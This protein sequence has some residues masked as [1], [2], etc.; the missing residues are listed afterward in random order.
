MWNFT[1]S[2]AQ[3]YVKSIAQHSKSAVQKTREFSTD[4]WVC[5]KPST[6]SCRKIVG[7]SIE[8]WC[9]ELT[10]LSSISRTRRRGN[11]KLREFVDCSSFHYPQ[12]S[13]SNISATKRIHFSFPWHKHLFQ[14]CWQLIHHKRA[15]YS[16]AWIRRPYRGIVRL[17]CY[18]KGLF[19]ATLIFIQTTGFSLQQASGAF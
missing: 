15:W 18:F 16:T 10:V 9:L 14:S 11:R 1:L 3:Y 2:C 17:I 6:K 12:L 19:V 7:W 13:S 8:C 4:C 5:F